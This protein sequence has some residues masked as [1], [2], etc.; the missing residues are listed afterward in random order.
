[1]LADRNAAPTAQVNTMGTIKRKAGKAAG[2]AKEV[3]AEV[4]G[5]GKL[6]EEA[7]AEQRQAEQDEARDESGGLKPLGNLDR[8]T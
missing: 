5:D 1:V 8:L 3:I 7:K 6:Q 4:I 2:K